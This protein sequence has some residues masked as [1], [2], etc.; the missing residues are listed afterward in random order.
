MLEIRMGID[1]LD[2]IFWGLQGLIIVLA[3]RQGRRTA[4]TEPR[5]VTWQYCAIAI[6]VA[7][8][9]RLVYCF[10]LASGGFWYLVPDDVARWL[11]SWGWAASPYLISWDG[12]W[13][14]GTF[15]VHGAAM[16][17]LRD[18]LVA[19]KFVSAFYNLLPLVGIFVLAQGLYRN[20]WLSSVAVVAAAPWW[21]HILLGTGAMTEMP[22]TGFM[23]AGA[24]LL[25][26]ALDGR[27]EDRSAGAA[28]M[29]A[30]FCFLAGTAFHMVAWMMLVSFLLVFARRLLS[31]RKPAV[32]RR[33]P[34]FL[35]ISL[36]YCI[37]W[38]LG[39]WVKFGSPLAFLAAYDANILKYG[40]SLSLTA[41]LSAY[42][43]AF[44]YDGWLILPALAVSMIG[45]WSEGSERRRR[46]RLVIG[47][48]LV[49]LLVQASS[50]IV[51]NPSTG[52]PVRATVALVAAL[53]PIAV[54]G[55]V[56]AWPDGWAQVRARKTKLVPLVAVLVLAV[57]WVAV[58]H[59][60]VFQRVRS[61]GS[62]DPDAIAMGA[63]LREACAQPD[64]TG[65]VPNERIVHVWVE[66]SS[67]YPD[68]SIQY[69]FGSPSRVRQHRSDEEVEKVL[70]AVGRDE[71]LV[72]DR[73]I[74]Q[75]GYEKIVTIGKYQVFSAKRKRGP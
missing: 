17:V 59:S 1:A 8:T 64:G 42:P 57:A 53:F 12:I 73:P 33:L 16:T 25:L 43:L 11:L 31:T 39:C 72:T 19:S 32:R 4:T 66:T 54:A 62:L 44:L 69:L 20:A 36:G 27:T 37:L 48:V 65:R 67:T 41:R 38:T 15:Y 68:F 40:T 13:Q 46:E 23:L 51:G 6:L 50:A 70:S 74:T 71:W 14:G 9:W 56:A 30:A 52:L 63:W 28:L 21:L 22:V 45:A 60:R 55:I 26:L 7:W 29:G 47:G 2:W 35:G 24:G 49:T 3:W 10:V 34:L 75:P 5:S 61:Q 18:P 58:N